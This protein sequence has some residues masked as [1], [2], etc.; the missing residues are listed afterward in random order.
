MIVQK[1]KTSDQNFA[2]GFKPKWIAKTTTSKMA[3]LNDRH[4]A[5]HA[6]GV[7]VKKSALVL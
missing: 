7:M 4:N 5:T 1:P 3:K 6:K 2:C